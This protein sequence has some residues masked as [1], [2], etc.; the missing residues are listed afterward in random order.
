[1]LDKC[2]SAILATVTIFATGLV[3]AECA[4][5]AYKIGSKIPVFTVKSTTSLSDAWNSYL[6]DY[7][8]TAR[9]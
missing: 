5:T 6:E 1:M 7:P 2:S 8:D 9:V 3:Y 4:A